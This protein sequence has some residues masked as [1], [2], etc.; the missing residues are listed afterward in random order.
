MAGEIIRMGDP[1]T[2]GGKVIEGSPIDIC[3]GK[4][5]AYLGHQTFCP[6]CKGNFPIIEGALTTTFYGKGV[7]LAGMKTACGAVLIA[8]QITDILEMGGGSRSGALAS[9]NRKQAAITEAS[10]TGGGSNPSNRFAKTGDDVDLEQYFEAV[11]PT[12]APIDLTYRINSGHTKL[13][14]AAFASNGATRAFPVDVEA[15]LVFWR[16]PI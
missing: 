9:S 15:Q 10:S 5:I 3:H 7:A 13:T 11:D 16:A 8:T 1:T 2:H 6:Q 14:E 12:G 4:P